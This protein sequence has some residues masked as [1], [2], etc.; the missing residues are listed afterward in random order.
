MK[1]SALKQKLKIAE[2]S[3]NLKTFAE[4]IQKAEKKTLHYKKLHFRKEVDINVRPL[5]KS[6]GSGF[7]TRAFV[8][9]IATIPINHYANEAR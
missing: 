4:N 8:I 6:V 7:R 2:R 5:K 9:Q 3:S 1:I